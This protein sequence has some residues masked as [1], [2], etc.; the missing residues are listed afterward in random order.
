MSLKELKFLKLTVIIW[1][2]LWLV[3]ENINNVSQ[4]LIFIAS[5]EFTYILDHHQIIV[6]A[7]ITAFEIHEENVTKFP[8]NHM[9]S[10][11]EY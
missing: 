3:L 5:E 9:T 6:T 4:S 8:A 11:K 10:I 7:S 2:F 1:L